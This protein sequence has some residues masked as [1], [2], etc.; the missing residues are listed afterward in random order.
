MAAIATPQQENIRWRELEEDDCGYPRFVLAPRV[1]IVPEQQRSKVEVAAANRYH[2]LERPPV[3]SSA[4]ERRSWPKFGDAV[5]DDAGT[6][7]TWVSTEEIPFERPGSKAAVGSVLMVCRICAMKGDHSTTECPYKDLAL[8]NALQ[9]AAFVDRRP[10]VNHT[11]P[12]EA[13]KIADVH[14]FTRKDADKSGADVM[15]RKSNRWVLVTNLS[16][17]TREADLRD[18][19]DY[20]DICKRVEVFMDKNTGSCKGFVEF[21]ESEDAKRAIRILNGHTYDGRTIRVEWAPPVRQDADRGGDDVMERRSDR[22]VIVTNLSKETCE[23]HLQEL[24]SYIDNGI[25]VL[26][27]MDE[28]TGSCRGLGFVKFAESK[29]AERAIRIFDGHCYGGHIIR[30]RGAKLARKD[31]D[32]SGAHVYR[33]N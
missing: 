6:R 32:R 8:E 33:F 10:T 14:V 12:D 25:R 28:K 7:V 5:K 13:F 9:N 26:V 31:A 18:L 11:A 1:V 22:C 19:F 23:A 17:E 2:E 27:P 15:E 4:I 21:A 20:V 29:D 24:F 30:V 3:P 16:E